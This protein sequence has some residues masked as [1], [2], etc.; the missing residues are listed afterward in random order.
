MQLVK[1]I[2]PYRK[3]FI[4]ASVAKLAEAMFE[5]YLPIL[6]AQILDVGIPS[7]NRNL[8]IH[9]GIKMLVLAL[10][11]FGCAVYCQYISSVASQGTAMTIRDVLVKKISSFSYNE[12]D[13]FGASSLTNRI[14]TDVNNYQWAVAMTMRLFTRAPFICIGAVVMSLKIDKELSIVFFFII[15]ILAVVLF[16]F[17]RV[18]SSLFR[19]VQQ[20]LDEFALIIKE[21]LSG[22][23]VIRAFATTEQETTRAK[24]SADE[25]KDASN[26]VTMFSSWM[27]PINSL[28]LN[29]GIIIILYLGANRVNKGHL[30]QGDLLSL[31]M[32]ATKILYAVVVTANLVV[33]YTKAAASNKRIVEI[34][35][36][37]SQVDFVSSPDVEKQNSNTEIEFKDVFFAYTNDHYLIENASFKINKG[38][39]LGV[40][41]T[42]GAG[43][44]T[45]INLIQRFYDVSSGELLIDGANIKD[46][47]K[48][49][50]RDKIGVV[51]QNNVLFTGTIAE[52][53]RIGNPKASDEHIIKALDVAQCTEFI[54]NLSD[55]IESLVFEGGKNFSGGQ[56]QRL[57][58]ARA[59]VKDPDILILDDSLS[60]LDYKTDLNLR[61]SLK[62][63]NDELTTIIISQ[64][65]SSVVSADKIIVMSYG[66]IV[67]IGP[68]KELLS[69]CK[70][71]QEIYESQTALEGNHEQ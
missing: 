14:T 49:Q 57:T 18:A 26:K 45:I 34:L 42:T 24:A 28:V 56:K 12:L 19:K 5:L 16:V 29:I 59:L 22:I 15:P 4:L 52:N 63:Y 31:S 23:R 20:K 58:I 13:Q 54:E 37:E 36:M 47:P 66:K 46:Y 61:K 2:K 39:T 70:D 44:T 53:I 38:E 43:K 68:H 48:N 33:I 65:V 21:N 25:I 11:G 6:M 55:G 8:I 3:E 60:A 51:P 17:M 41:G 1:Y 50:L 7:G 62:N 71:Y 67:D 40:V 10:V 64:R 69:R 32:Y 9:T 30:M 35:N 27:Q